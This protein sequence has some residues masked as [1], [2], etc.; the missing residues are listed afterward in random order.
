MTSCASSSHDIPT[1]HTRLLPESESHPLLFRIV[2]VLLQSFISAINADELNNGLALPASNE[3]VYNPP[4]PTF[5]RRPNDDMVQ[6]EREERK[7]RGRTARNE[8]V[9]VGGGGG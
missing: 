6:N 7:E 2:V 4:A 9:L 5:M 1:A 8:P 3:D